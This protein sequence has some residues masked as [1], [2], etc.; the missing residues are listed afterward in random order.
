MHAT[1]SKPLKEIISYSHEEAMRLGN[2][3]ISTE[4]LLLGMTKMNNNTVVHLLQSFNVEIT[5]LRK[6]VE[7]EIKHKQNVSP[8]SMQQVSLNKNLNITRLS[9]TEEAAEVIRE[10]QSEAQEANSKKVEADHLLLAILK[11]KGNTRASILQHIRAG[12]Q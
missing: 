5:E 2:D 12:L 9:L 7:Q 6:Q 11:D 10:S 8:S 4:H 3:F 1:F